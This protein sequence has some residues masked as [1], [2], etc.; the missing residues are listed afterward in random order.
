MNFN[1]LQLKVLFYI[2]IL[3]VSSLSYCAQRAQ[4]QTSAPHAASS[5]AASSSIAALKQKLQAQIDDWHKN[6]KFAGATVGVVLADGT[7]FGL[8]AGYSDRDKKTPM[9]TGDLM[10]AGR[11]GKTNS[12]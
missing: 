3:L 10:L 6:G 7:S 8:A 4:G 1:N 2:A 9:R 12:A 5:N 11:A